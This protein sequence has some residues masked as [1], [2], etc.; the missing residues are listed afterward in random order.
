MD[1]VPQ[2]VGRMVSKEATYGCTVEGQYDSNED[3]DTITGQAK[4]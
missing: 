2:K 3:M 4:K 1:E